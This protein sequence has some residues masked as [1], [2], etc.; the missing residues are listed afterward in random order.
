[1]FTTGLTSRPRCPNCGHTL[2][3]DNATTENYLTCLMCAREFDVE[4][5]SRRMTPYELHKRYGIK[6]IQFKKDV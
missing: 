2:Y 1:M 5:N 3:R 6:L 4:L